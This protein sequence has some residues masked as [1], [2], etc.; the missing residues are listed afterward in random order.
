MAFDLVPG[1]FL[2]Y[3]TISMP[4]IWNDEDD[5]L[6]APSTPSGL[7]VSEDP[8]NVYIEA[9]VPGIDPKNIE[10]TFQDGYLWIRGETREEEKDKNRKYYRQATKSFSYRVAVPGDIDANQ[11]P[12]ATYRHG[13]MTVSFAKSPK[14]QPKKIQIKALNE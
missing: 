11:E 3:P 2:S 8:N 9:A 1:R 6:T 4:S 10:M 13:I 7:S 12:V 5:W 14:A